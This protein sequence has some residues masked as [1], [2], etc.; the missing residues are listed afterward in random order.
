MPIAES[1]V[2]WVS[3]RGSGLVEKL[4]LPAIMQGFQTTIKHMFSP[5][6]TQQFPEEARNCRRIIAACTGS[7]A[8]K[9]GG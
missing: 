1:E 7:I 2:R 8:T 4:Y 6:V 3:R 5:N 9:R